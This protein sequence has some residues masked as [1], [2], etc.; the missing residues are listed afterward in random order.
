MIYSS[1]F[2]HGE[3]KLNVQGRIGGDAELSERGEQY[4]KSL[5]EYIQGENLSDVST[6]FQS[7]HA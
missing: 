2:Q 4:A 7:P 5:A 6:R 3:S 1:L